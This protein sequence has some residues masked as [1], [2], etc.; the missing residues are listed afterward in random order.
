MGRLKSNVRE[1]RY[2]H[3][4]TLR[5]VAVAAET[6][7]PRASRFALAHVCRKPQGRASGPAFFFPRFSTP[8][9]NSNL[10]TR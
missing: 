1:Y 3:S 7:P 2:R 4:V 10:V 9:V 6:P 8:S 5:R